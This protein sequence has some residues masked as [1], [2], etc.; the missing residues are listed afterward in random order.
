MDETWSQGQSSFPFWGKCCSPDPL[1]EDAWAGGGPSLRPASPQKQPHNHS[2]LWTCS[3][4]KCPE[5]KSD[6]NL[7]KSTWNLV[8]KFIVP[9]L[10][11]V[12]PKVKRSAWLPL[13]GILKELVEIVPVALKKILRPFLWFS[14][15]PENKSCLYPVRPTPWNSPPEQIQRWALLTQPKYPSPICPRILPPFPLRV[16]KR[17]GDRWRRKVYERRKLR[18]QTNLSLTSKESKHFF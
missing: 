3:E 8:S 6:L 7:G 12:I 2:F 17:G 5:E 1:H 10:Q 4:P 15:L 11:D 16:S 13:C 18:C 14:C 9:H